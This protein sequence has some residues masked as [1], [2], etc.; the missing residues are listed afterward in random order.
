MAMY[1]GQ[2]GRVTIGGALASPLRAPLGVSGSTVVLAHQTTGQPLVGVLAAGDR[3]TFAGEPGNPVHTVV[4]GPLYLPQDS[5]DGVRT[6]LVDVAF[7]P[8]VA[9][10]LGAGNA[11]VLANAVAQTTEWSLSATQ[12]QLDATVQG[13]DWRRVVG[14]EAAW[15]GRVGVRLDLSDPRQAALVDRFASGNA[16]GEVAALTLIV[17]DTPVGTSPS[18]VRGFVGGVLLTTYQVQ[19][20]RGSLVSGSFDFQGTGSLAPIWI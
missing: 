15:S 9:A 3:L 11:L 4:G 5:V 8:A 14:G 17:D 2:R 13:D 7:T 1:R 19:S 6:R 10:P 16:V 18:R 20:Q 12:E